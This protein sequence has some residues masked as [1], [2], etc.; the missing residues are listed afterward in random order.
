M[1]SSEEPLLQTVFQCSQWSAPLESPSKFKSTRQQN[2]FDAWK[3]KPLHGQFVREIDGC[4]DASQQWRWLFNSNL[5][6]ETEGLIMAAQD[7]AI[8]TNCVKVNISIRLA[9]F[10]VVSVVI[11]LS[12]WITF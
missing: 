11:M 8:S 4:Y 2:H 6:K 12:L 7:Q 5:K 3:T 1:A 10:Y 9:L